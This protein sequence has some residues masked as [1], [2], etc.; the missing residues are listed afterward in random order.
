MHNTKSA[1]KNPQYCNTLGANYGKQ[2]SRQESNS[3]LIHKLP[4]N[5]LNKKEK[6]FYGENYKSSVK[7]IVDHACTDREEAMCSRMRR[8]DTTKM[9]PWPML[10]TGST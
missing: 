10:P 9:P 6:N 4:M 2:K 8:V 1:Y 5:K 3:Q 7:E